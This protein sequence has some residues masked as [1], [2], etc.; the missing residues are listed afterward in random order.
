MI[1]LNIFLF[2]IL[3]VGLDYNIPIPSNISFSED[4]ISG[5]VECITYIIIDD[6]TVEGE[7]TFDVSLENPTNGLEIGN[8]AES[9]VVI[10]DDGKSKISLCYI[11]DDHNFLSY[12]HDLYFNDTVTYNVC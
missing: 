7:H 5:T 10:V 9:T 1:K 8:Q 12:V 3:V 4:S 6:D 2:I 11:Y